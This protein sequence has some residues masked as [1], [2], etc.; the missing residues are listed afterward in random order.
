M[1]TSIF[2]GYVII[3]DDGYE[4]SILIPPGYTPQQALDRH[5]SECRVKAARLTVEAE[6]ADKALAEI[7]RQQTGGRKR[8]P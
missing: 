6:R 3:K 7:D 1:K 8:K 2:N 4:M 5:A